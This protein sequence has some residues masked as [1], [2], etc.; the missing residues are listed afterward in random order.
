MNN[1]NIC[2][3]ILGEENDDINYMTRPSI[4]ND[5]QVKAKKEENKYKKAR[6]MSIINYQLQDMKNK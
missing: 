2:Y 5:L 1:N 3:K 6:L 4:L